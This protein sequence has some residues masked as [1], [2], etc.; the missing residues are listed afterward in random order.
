[1]SQNFNEL[2]K[3]FHTSVSSFVHLLNNFKRCICQIV[4]RYHMNVTLSCSKW[5]H[6]TVVSCRGGCLKHI[7]DTKDLFIAG[8]FKIHV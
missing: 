6:L 1:M 2:E 7:S 4:L 8:A 5:S 3:M